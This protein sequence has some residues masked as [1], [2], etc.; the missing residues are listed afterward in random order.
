M[1]K[2]RAKLPENFWY[3]IED[4]AKKS[5]LLF[6]TTS[7]YQYVLEHDFSPIAV[8]YW[9]VLIYSDKPT[10]KSQ[11]DFVQR[12]GMFLTDFIEVCAHG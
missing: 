9:G 5:P 6:S 1:G 12:G 7:A 3:M 11:K 2:I 4:G 10:H 8:V